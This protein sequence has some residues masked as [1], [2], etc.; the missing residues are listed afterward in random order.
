V[1]STT[2]IFISIPRFPMTQPHITRDQFMAFFRSDFFHEELST[3]DCIEVFLDALN[4]DHDLTPELITQLFVRYDGKH[5]EAAVFAHAP[6]LLAT[7]KES[8][9][10][11]DE[12]D[13][14]SFSLS[15]LLKR[16]RSVIAKI[17]RTEAPSTA[18][19]ST[20]ERAAL[21][22]VHDALA[23]AHE[24]LSWF[25]ESNPSAAGEHFGAALKGRMEDALESARRTFTELKKEPPASV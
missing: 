5:T 23:D 4:G 12:L 1:N 2:F 16:L 25:Y 19:S 13:C 17:E 8:L 7:C 14:S 11:L 15:L 22:N 3:D 9:R 24:A 6:D 18:P 20:D 10:V 21:A